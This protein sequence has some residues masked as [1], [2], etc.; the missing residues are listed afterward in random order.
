MSRSDELA[1]AVEN[2]DKTIDMLE[3]SIEQKCL[4]LI[5]RRQPMA[6][7][8]RFITSVM[9]INNDLERIGDM[10]GSIAHKAKI[11]N[12]L[13]VI[14]TVA[15]VP[16]MAAA[17]HDMLKKS[18]QA[19]T[20]RDSGLARQICC[21]DKDIDA[22]YVR[23]FRETLACMS[24]GQESVRAGIEVVMIAKHLERMADHVTNI[25]EDIVYM[26]EAKT[27]KHKFEN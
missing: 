18:A 27:I 23:L 24:A 9:K 19:L 22:I 20:G 16:V 12:R 26:V 21:M 10:A 3:I 4:E 6:S 11:L 5:A 13:P 7:D 1:E 17:I 15:D 2:D 8:L 25:A 14:R